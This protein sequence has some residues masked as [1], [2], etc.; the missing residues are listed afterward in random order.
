VVPLQERTIY[1]FPDRVGGAIA[2]L[3]FLVLQNPSAAPHDCMNTLRSAF[4]RVN[5]P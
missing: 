2:A 4:D 1:R 3:I 5:Q